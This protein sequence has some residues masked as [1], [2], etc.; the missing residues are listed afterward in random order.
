MLVPVQVLVRVLL[1]VSVLVLVLAR[2]GASDRKAR[3]VA[4]NYMTGYGHRLRH[5]MLQKIERVGRSAQR[6]NG[7]TR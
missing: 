3:V 1:L 5:E 6:S 7:Q 4:V 2:I